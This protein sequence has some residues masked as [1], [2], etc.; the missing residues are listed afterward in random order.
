MSLRLTL[1][2]VFVLGCC[3]VTVTSAGCEGCSGSFR[4]G[5]SSSIPD[6][7]KLPYWGMSADDISNAVHDARS[8]ADESTTT[9]EWPPKLV[10]PTP[11]GNKFGALMDYSSGSADVP[12]KFSQ[13]SGT[14]KPGFSTPSGVSGKSGLMKTLVL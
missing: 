9:M 2:A 1:L 11:A 8:S 5:S 12:S 3:L 10:L 14:T 13:F 7:S 6:Y 4:F